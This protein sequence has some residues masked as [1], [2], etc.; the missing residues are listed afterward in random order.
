MSVIPKKWKESEAGTERKG[1]HL[2]ALSWRLNFKK[3]IVLLA[4]SIS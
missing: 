1:L 4:V 3:V 2:Y